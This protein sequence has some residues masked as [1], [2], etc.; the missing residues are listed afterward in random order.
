MVKL[1]NW[2]KDRREELPKVGHMDA[3]QIQEVETVTPVVIEEAP[4]PLGYEE[5]EWNAEDY[6]ALAIKNL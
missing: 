3:G 2:V 4:Q 5:D 1:D 6:A